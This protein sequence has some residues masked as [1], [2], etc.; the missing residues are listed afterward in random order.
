MALPRPVPW[1]IRRAPAARR[2]VGALGPAAEDLARRVV[3]RAPA[4]AR[5]PLYVAALATVAARSIPRAI[6]LGEAL[7]PAVDDARARIAL[8][9]IHQQAGAI[10][11]PLALLDEVAAAR[12]PARLDARLRAEARLLAAPI[13][14][15]A[16]AVPRPWPGDRRI[17]YHA[18]QCLP[19]H[20]SGYATRTHGLVTSLRAQG[21]DVEV[22]ARLGY[23][24]DRADFIGV[25]AVGPDAVVDGVPYRFVPDRERGQLALDHE[26]Y[27]AA[28]VA[29]LIERARLQRPAVIHSASN[30]IVGLAGAAAARALG[31]PSIYEVRG[32]WHLTRASSQPWYRGSDHYRLIDRFEAT[33]AASSDHVF[34]IT[35][36]V[37]DILADLGVPRAR[38]SVLP[39]AVDTDRFTPR[40]R[41]A[42]LAARWGLGDHPVI[43]YLGSFKAYEGLDDLLEAAARLRARRGPAFRVLLVGD[44]D[45]EPDLRARATR[46]GLDD[47]VVF[48]GR[49]PHAE[50]VRYY[51]LVDVMAFPRKGLPVCEVV[52]P[53]KPFEAMAMAR[54]VV[55]SSVAALTEIVSHERT[56]LVH[57]KDDPD[58]LAA[59]LARC[60]DQ[61]AWAR[62]LAE[63]GARWVRDHRSWQRVTS[64]I[65]AVY[66]ELG[67]R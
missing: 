12:R 33:A 47:V 30:H 66:Q 41:D 31:V 24:N 5:G 65:D 50:M 13:A 27:Q 56:G 4:F 32:L 51:S 9:R 1:L 62:A 16:A 37:G 29:S 44:G 45:A 63:H 8:A 6:E 28:S 7:L 53:L 22:H 67:R 55:V 19:H 64:E 26:A 49:Q 59:Q 21:W 3:P 17:L 25:P 36:A 35:G 40:P 38:M 61:P 48:T 60:L 15:A 34:V 43:G 18:S 11:R 42:A 23:P 57:R 20:S 52:S 58:D 14:P 54:T 39:N 2:A 46:L 10:H